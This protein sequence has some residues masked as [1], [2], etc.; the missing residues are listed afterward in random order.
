MP[1][2]LSQRMFGKS[3][4]VWKG[5]EFKYCVAAV[6]IKITKAAVLMQRD[7]ALTIISTSSRDSQEQDDR[8]DYPECIVYSKIHNQRQNIQCIDRKTAYN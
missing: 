8:M 2:K 4:S 3:M 5:R 6:N 7:F 1:R